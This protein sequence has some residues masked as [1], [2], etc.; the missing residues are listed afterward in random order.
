MLYVNTLSIA[1]YYVIGI[2]MN[3]IYIAMLWEYICENNDVL[4]SQP[5]YGNTCDYML[6]R[7]IYVTGIYAKI[8]MFSYL[9]IY[10][11]LIQLK[12]RWYF[13][14]NLNAVHIYIIYK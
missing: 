3:I 5:C 11:G 2:Y 8:S 4:F 1:I 9:G 10:V 13:T 6:H 7:A 14:G 12:K